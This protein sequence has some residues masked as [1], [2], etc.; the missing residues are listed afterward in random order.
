M[1]I[2]ITGGGGFIG[3]NLKSTISE[4]NNFKL[5]PVSYKSTPEQIFQK[6]KESNFIIHLAGVNRSKNIE[7]FYEGNV[8]IT[9]KIC[10][11]N[12]RL[13]QESGKGIP[14]IFTSS[15][16][17]EQ[18]N[19]YGKSKAQAEDLL[20]NLNK[21]FKIPVFIFRLPNVF[22]K[23]C[24]PNY[25][26]FVTTILF[27]IARNIP[28]E[29]INSKKRLKLLYIDDLVQLIIQIIEGKKIKMI[30][31][32]EVFIEKIY[33]AKLEDIVSTIYKFKESNSSLILDGVGEGLCRAL[34]STYLS[35]LPKESF[36]YK[37]NS[38]KDKRGVFVEFF[39]TT[40]SG[41]FSFF[42]AHP[43]VTR[44]EH[45]HN[46]KNE[47]FLVCQGSARFDFKNL[48]NGETHTIFTSADQ[49]KVINSIPGWAH[50]ITNIGKENLIVLL[51]ANEIFDKSNP[52]T[53][54]FK[55][56]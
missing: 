27:N 16:H 17:A 23:W 24:K 22:G 45:Y 15:I 25:N 2:L 54:Q 11:A 55:I 6:I 46:S 40:N 20:L 33:S 52:D 1:N 5:I 12:L 35:Y 28:I 56:K 47:K 18:N 42:T 32:N 36:E 34:Y 38:K 3:K 41:Q 39:K 26:S 13:F 43:D 49:F 4:Y 14:I 7:D 31:S 10:D 19:E 21:N 48:E 51:W 37:L 8:Q 29:Y 44:G 53:F 50:S 9:K 30:S